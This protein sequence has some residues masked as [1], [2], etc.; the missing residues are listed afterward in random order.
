V[1]YKAIK[2]AD[3]FSMSLT[4]A[5]L[6]ILSREPLYGYD[7]KKRFESAL[8]GE[9]SISYG[10]LYPALGR[11]ESAGHVIRESEQGEK[12]NDRHLYRITS[13]GQAHFEAWLGEAP[14]CQVRLK[15]DLSLR[16][17]QF[18]HLESK[19][20]KL[21]LKT[22]R[23]ATIEKRAGLV[24]S[25]PDYLDKWMKSIAQRGIAMCDA[26]LTWIDGLIKSLDV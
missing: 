14:E 12:S 26:E 1:I 11:L 5:L 15:D 13:K 19:Q 6:G 23:A 17:S 18:G 22:Y 20:R 7:L 2:N 21:V 3:T 16:L 4:N 25:M 24:A 9:W 8:G 10:Q